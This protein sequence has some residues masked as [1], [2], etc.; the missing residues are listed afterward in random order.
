MT[1][2]P[3]SHPGGTEDDIRDEG[4]INCGITDKLRTGVIPSYTQPVC[5]YFLNVP[6]PNKLFSNFQTPGIKYDL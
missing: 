4:E 2:I 6:T 1:H 3:L 5:Q